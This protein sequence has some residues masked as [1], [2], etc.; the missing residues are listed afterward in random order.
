[1]NQRFQSAR[2]AKGVSTPTVYGG[3][4]L[5]LVAF[6]GKASVLSRPVSA[7]NPTLLRRVD[8]LPQVISSYTNLTDGL[9]LSINEL[10]PLHPGLDREIWALSDG[11][12]NVEEDGLFA[13]VARANAN[14]ITI[15][16]I[17]LGFGAEIDPSRLK[18]VAAGTRNG[19][20]LSVDTARELGEVVKRMAPSHRRHRARVTVFC[21]DVSPS[22]E[23]DY[24]DA[25][26][27]ID[28][29]RETMFDL[30]RYKQKMW[31]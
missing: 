22:M 9:R 29:V 26:R 2:S 20:Y 24:M 19:K 5:A 21:V 7:Y 11:Q 15:N 10:L 30:I 28:V 18:A 16:V 14:R 4:L 23:N 8:Q 13:Q 27:K 3:D 25:K 31:S 12:D 6:G 1:M 17:G